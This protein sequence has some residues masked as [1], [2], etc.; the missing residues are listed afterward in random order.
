MSAHL[1]KCS[2]GEDVLVVAGL[3]QTFLVEPCEVFPEGEC[4]RCRGRGTLT[5]E[6]ELEGTY[7][8][9]GDKPSAKHPATAVAVSVPCPRCEGTGV[10]GEPIERGMIAVDPLL[11]G[12][13]LYGERASGEAAH[14]R[15]VCSE[16]LLAA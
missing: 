16:E 7:S 13:V 11:R 5:A 2:C 6:R 12:R 10:V 4:P 9:A 3:G 15:H 1:S 8:L 14:R